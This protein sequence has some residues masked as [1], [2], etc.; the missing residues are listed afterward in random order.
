MGRV[1][2]NQEGMVKLLRTMAAGNQ[3]GLWAGGE[4]G[5]LEFDQS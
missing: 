2:G 1:K 3:Y 5:A 4:G